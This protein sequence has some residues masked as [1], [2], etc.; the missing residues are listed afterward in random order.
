MERMVST[1]DISLVVMT[2][3]Q[4]RHRFFVN[5]LAA[6]FAVNGVVSEAKRPRF[7]TGAPLA[8]SSSRGEEDLLIREHFAGWDAAEQAYFG[9]E[10]RFTAPDSDILA[11]PRGG[12]NAPEVFEWIRGRGPR[13]LVLFGTS[14][15]RDPLLSA[16]KDRAINMH[17]GLSPY[18]RGTA[19]NFWPLADGLPECVGITV[20]I[21]AAEVD[22]GPILAQ[23]R[24]VMA[25]TDSPHDIGCKAIITGVELLARAI[26]AY[27][28]GS[29]TPVPQRL[30]G[31]LFRQ[32]DFSV[33]AVRT[34]RANFANGMIRD[35]LQQKAER[36][37]KYP[38]IV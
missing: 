16:F 22:A 11:V 27:D 23:A 14:I 12:S 20:H 17:L 1:P 21:A 7:S 3:D 5:F 6:R 4:P 8:P 38:I 13:Y 35:Y 37:A 2:S 32:R 26:S 33:E 9:K 18:Y 10:E 34:L 19:T 25:P 28:A 29:I 31:K 24:P 30:G 15:I 36:D